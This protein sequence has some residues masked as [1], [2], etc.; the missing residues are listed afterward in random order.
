MNGRDVSQREFSTPLVGVVLRPSGYVMVVI[1]HA[2]LWCLSI[3]MGRSLKFQ[4]Q[5][6]CKLDSSDNDIGHG[7][8]VLKTFQ[9][10]GER[11]NNYILT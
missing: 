2:D 1:H 4:W 3:E 6:I 7:A 8:E 9:N 11:K 10:I 5:C